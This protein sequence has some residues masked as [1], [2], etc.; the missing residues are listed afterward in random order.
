M[1]E[2]IL[3]KTA[4]GLRAVTSGC[5]GMPKAQKAFMLAVDGRSAAAEIRKKLSELD[6]EEFSRIEQTLFEE[7]YLRTWLPSVPTTDRVPEHSTGL[8]FP[9]DHDDLDFTTPRFNSSSAG[10]VFP[11]DHD[12]LDFTTPRFN[13]SSHCPS[14]E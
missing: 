7:G 10:L 5:L 1:N 8:V 13:S 11:N 2:E 12:D 4:K 14:G 3:S 6:D 9:N